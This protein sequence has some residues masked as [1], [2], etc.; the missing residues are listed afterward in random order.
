MGRDANPNP[1]PDLGCSGTDLGSPAA[2]KRHRTL[3]PT[4]GATTRKH[5]PSA[6]SAGPCRTATHRPPAPASHVASRRPRGLAAIQVRSRPRPHSPTR[7]SASKA[8]APVTCPAQDAPTGPEPYRPSM[9]RTSTSHTS[10]G[11]RPPTSHRASPRRAHIAPTR[12]SVSRARQDTF[13][14]LRRSPNSRP[15]PTPQDLGLHNQERER[16]REREPASQM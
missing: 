13:S 5:R 12:D 7:P 9:G 16:E 8:T 1:N 15:P 10:V 14:P 6:H 4:K 2:M 3:T 11:C